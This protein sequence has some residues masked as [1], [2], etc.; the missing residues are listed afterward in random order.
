MGKIFDESVSKFSVVDMG[1]GVGRDLTFLA[2]EYL[3]ACGKA[4]AAPVGSFVG[5]DN[6]KSTERILTA[7]SRNRNVERQVKFVKQNLKQ[8]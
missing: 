3:S 2:E 6:H 1:C 5:I 4:D 7:L 8:V